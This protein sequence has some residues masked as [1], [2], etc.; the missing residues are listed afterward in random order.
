MKF[1]KTTLVIQK[2]RNLIRMVLQDNSKHSFFNL[3]ISDVLYIYIEDENYSKAYVMP[4]IKDFDL[5]DVDLSQEHQDFVQR[6]EEKN[7]KELEAIDENISYMISNS[8][9]VR[10]E[11]FRTISEA[12]F[13]AITEPQFLHEL[14]TRLK[15]EKKKVEV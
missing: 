11:K 6:I 7:S 10:T 3:L 13:L 1:K 5:T 12:L 4:D 9:D 2:G 15:I 14:R 8:S